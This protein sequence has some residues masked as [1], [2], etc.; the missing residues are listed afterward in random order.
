ME[1][2]YHDGKIVVENLTKGCSSTA[3]KLNFHWEMFV[4]GTFV[5]IKC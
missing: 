1:I 5:L 3:L 4:H 2:G